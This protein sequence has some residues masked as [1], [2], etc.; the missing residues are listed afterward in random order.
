MLPLCRADSGESR[1]FLGAILS[2]QNTLDIPYHQ[3]HL[4]RAHVLLADGRPNQFGGRIAMEAR[5]KEGKGESRRRGT[6]LSTIS[7]GR[8]DLWGGFTLNTL[9]ATRT[10]L[11][12]Y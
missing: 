10:T 11:I 12:V 9:V 6:K 8:R 3:P 5:R 2:F 1:V 7:H 4:K